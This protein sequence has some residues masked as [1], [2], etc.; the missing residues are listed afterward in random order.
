MEFSNAILG[1]REYRMEGPYSLP[2]TIELYVHSKPRTKAMR[3]T[4][5]I[6][7][8]HGVNI[9]VNH[10]T[11]FAAA[12]LCWNNSVQRVENRISVEDF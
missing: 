4:V 5:E 1:I 2:T 3:Y 9:S 10:F 11:E 6:T 12:V 8:V 7:N